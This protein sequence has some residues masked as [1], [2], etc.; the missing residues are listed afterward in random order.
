LFQED[1][2]VIFLDWEKGAAGPSY[3]L[4]AANTQ[5]VGRQLAILIYDLINLGE[6]IISLIFFKC[7]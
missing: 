7:V 3:S 2:N 6:L 5:L 1:C 4:S